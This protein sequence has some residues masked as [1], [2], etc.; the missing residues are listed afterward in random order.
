[1]PSKSRTLFTSESAR[2]A[3]PHKAWVRRAKRANPRIAI[4]KLSTAPRVLSIVTDRDPGAHAPGFMLSCATRT[5]LLKNRK[6][7]SLTLIMIQKRGLRR[8]NTLRFFHAR[9]A[10]VPKEQLNFV[11]H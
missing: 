11:H 2:S 3:R 4:Q 10:L 9:R 5:V 1:M 7:A 8:S 6:I